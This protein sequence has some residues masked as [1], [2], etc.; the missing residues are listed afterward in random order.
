MRTWQLRKAKNHL[1]EVVDRALDQGP[2]MITRRGVETAVLI[3]VEEYRG[4][5]KPEQDLVDFFR[6]SPLAEADLDLERDPD[7]GRDLDL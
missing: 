1:S 4:L 5:R 7:P 6:S 2:Q 3:S